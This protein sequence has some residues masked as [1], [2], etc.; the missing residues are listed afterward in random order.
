MAI[1]AH[2]DDIEFGCGAT[3]AKW[4][5]VGTVVSMLVLTDGS[6][7]TWDVRADTG[8]LVARRRREQR[9]AAARLGATGEV[10]FL[11]QVDG[12]LSTG[13]EIRSAVA[14]TIRELRP[15]VVLGHDPWRRW[16]LHPDHRAAG[17][18]CTDAVA[19]ARDPLSFVDHGQPHHR[20]D[21]LL[22]FECEEP[23]HVEQVESTHVE[24][25]IEA[26]LAHRSQYESTHEITADDDGS[27]LVAFRSRIVEDCRQAGR[28]VGLDY[29]EAFKLVPTGS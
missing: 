19:T 27:E 26:L 3:L 18:L 22:L 5:S 9:D 16:R 29:G 6:K 11:D 21:H 20:P 24:A 2:P 23:D 13:V 25:K 7:G 1:A 8:A 15:D 4:A 17:F 12:E 10:R 28:R 14:K